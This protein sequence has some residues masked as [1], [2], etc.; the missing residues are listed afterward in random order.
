MFQWF[1]P[2]EID[3]D[4]KLGHKQSCAIMSQWEAVNLANEDSRK[5]MANAAKKS[6]DEARTLFLQL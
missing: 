5:L 3:K 2:V 1:D 6:E 4:C